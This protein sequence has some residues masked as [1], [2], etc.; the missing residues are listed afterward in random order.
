MSKKLLILFIV[1]SVPMVDELGCH[2][3]LSG[4][5]L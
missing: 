1:I 4:I 5:I 2:S 3:R